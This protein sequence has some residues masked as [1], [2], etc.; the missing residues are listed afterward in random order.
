MGQT[1][2]EMTQAAH[3]LL[4]M[5][6]N[7]E[8]DEQTF[9]DTV[10]GMGAIEKATSYCQVIFQINSEIEMFKNEIDRLSKRKKTLENN[11]QW[12]KTQLHNFFV[13]NGKKE[14]KAGTFT[15]TVRKSNFVDIPDVNK[16][17]KKYRTVTFSPDKKAIKKALESGTKVNGAK[18]EERE[19]IQIR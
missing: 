7:E 17:P 14:I 8:I 1:L 2:Y 9:N 18:L 10:E 3:M 11:V 6:E 19:S 12:M 15:V 5:F 4:E 13:S 16:I